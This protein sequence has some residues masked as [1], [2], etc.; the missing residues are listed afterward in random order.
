MSV[1]QFS[2]ACAPHPDNDLLTA[3]LERSQV[4]GVEVFCLSPEPDAE[5]KN[6]IKEL[7]NTLK[8]VL[9]KCFYMPEISD[10]E[11]SR[12]SAAVVA[13]DRAGQMVACLTNSF[14][15]FAKEGDPLPRLGAM[16]R[17]ISVLPEFRKK[18]IG[19]LLVECTECFMVSRLAMDE[20][21]YGE[22]ALSNEFNTAGKKLSSVVYVN[23][24]NV[25]QE[26]FALKLGYQ[27]SSYPWGQTGCFE[28]AFE[29]EVDVSSLFR[30]KTPEIPQ[31]RSWSFVDS[32]EEDPALSSGPIF[33]D[34][35]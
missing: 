18:G 7:R 32:D 5:H 19:R 14:R 13:F 29:K 1:F 10:R 2:L 34:D 12:E 23:T 15:L 21:E 35:E 24:G 22:C 31:K 4:L 27:E 3:L 26:A 25:E 28:R 33:S 20:E 9:S 8:P 16:N 11:L 17:Y 30:D 6:F